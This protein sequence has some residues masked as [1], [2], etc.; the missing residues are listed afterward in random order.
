MPA[1]W[2][3]GLAL[4]VLASCAAQRAH[5]VRPRAEPAGPD[6]SRLAIEGASP[7]AST[8]GATTL[9]AA[10]TT[11]G[12]AATTLGGGPAALAPEQATAG[13]ATSVEHAGTASA[14]GGVANV[15]T[16]TIARETLSACEQRVPLPGCLEAFPSRVA[17]PRVLSD[18]PVGELCGLVGRTHAPSACVYS[19]A[20]CKCAASVYCGGA[21]PNYLQ[22]AGMRW[23]CAAPPK[24]NDCPSQL[25]NGARC[26]V[27]GQ[28]CTSGSCGSSTECSC[29]AGKFRCVTRA[30][31]APP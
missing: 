13:G 27:E 19:G 3:I 4:G 20:V 14:T 21:A 24:P 7:A 30:V 1:A 2:K 22:Q 23:S 31:A 8:G 15:P 18:V 16:T 11:L 10:A 26:S 6:A 29:N 12:G 17:C 28:H 5:E 9:G 25:S